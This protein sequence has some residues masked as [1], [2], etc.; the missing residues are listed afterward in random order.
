MNEQNVSQ[1]TMHACQNPLGSLYKYGMTLIPAWISDH[2]LGKIC[3]EII[4]PFPNSNGCTVE[5]WEWISNFIPQFMVD[6]ITY[7]CWDKS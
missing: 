1:D 5:V 7:A 4:H 3:D 2:M 6:P